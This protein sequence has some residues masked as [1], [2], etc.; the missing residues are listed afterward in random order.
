MQLRSIGYKVLDGCKNLKYINDTNILSV[1]KIYNKH[2]EHGHWNLE[3]ITFN[4]YI[5]KLV[6]S[7]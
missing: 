2:F 1:K 5:Y 7:K 4:K 6:E 3:D